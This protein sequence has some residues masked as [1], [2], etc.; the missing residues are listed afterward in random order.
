[1]SRNRLNSGDNKL[2]KNDKFEKQVTFQNHNFQSQNPDDSLK[3]PLRP[4]RTRLHSMC[5]RPLELNMTT[6]ER[7]YLIS[8][9]EE[10]KSDIRDAIKLLDK[11]ER[12]K[13]KVKRIEKEIKVQKERKRHIKSIFVTFKYRVQRDIFYKL[14]PSSKY[15]SWIEFYGNYKIG[16]NRIF[17][18]IPPSPININWRNH[19][20][21]YIEKFCRR[22]F[23]WLLYISLY[24]IRK[25]LGHYGYFRI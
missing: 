11:F 21:Q 13:Q 25:V 6:N 14:L 23:S 3:S 17:G 7:E 19:D 16:G 9:N 1:M 2:E 22:F 24:I 20:K 4:S 8:E 18:V 15:Q 10:L 12:N 5:I